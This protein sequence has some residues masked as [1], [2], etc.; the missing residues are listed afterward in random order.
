MLTET[1]E[2]VLFYLVYDTIYYMCR[3]RSA[4]TCVSADNYVYS[5]GLRSHM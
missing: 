5:V 1:I 2:I 4:V 3:G